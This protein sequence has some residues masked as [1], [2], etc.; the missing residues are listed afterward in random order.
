[1]ETD[2][3]SRWGRRCLGAACIALVA[4]GCGS[5]AGDTGSIATSSTTT[6]ELNHVHAVV[7]GI[8]PGE[9]L[10]GTHMA[11]DVS[12][13]AGLTWHPA[14]GVPA[15]GV[16]A[17]I[18][19]PAGGYVAAFQADEGAPAN[20]MFSPDAAHWTPSGGMPPN[21]SVSNLVEGTGAVAWASVSGK[22]IYR[23]VDRGRTWTLVVPT[24]KLLT[25]L[26]DSGH[27]LLFADEAGIYVTSDVTP[28]EPP[29]PAFAQGVNT[30]G[31]WYA[32]PTCLVATLKKNGVATSKDGG[33]AWQSIDPSPALTIDVTLSFP[34]TGQTLFGMVATPSNPNIGMYTSDTGGTVWH[35]VLQ[36]PNVDNMFAVT[37]PTPYLLA[38]Q[39]G[40][41]VW[42]S[43]DKGTVWDRFSNI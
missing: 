6:R 41:Q 1:M 22:G 35:Q 3:T 7:D 13:D 18:R 29:A 28:V 20:M 25:A 8:K 34:S 37:A 40:I 12:E 9:L 33:R 39:W 5:A 36:Q 16:A 31:R 11:L 43:T 26:F 38:F 21:P 4:A 32:C 2:R 27:S 19:L 23:S 24:T 15:G 14:P 17:I 10:V 30:I 42:R